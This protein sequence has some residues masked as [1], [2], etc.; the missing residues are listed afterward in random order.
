[1]VSQD[2][3]S[4]RREPRSPGLLI[5]RNWLHQSAQDTPGVSAKRGGL[6]LPGLR[7]GVPAKN[8]DRRSRSSSRGS[9]MSKAVNI[10]IIGSGL[11]GSAFI[12]SLQTLRSPSIQ[13]NV[14]VIARSSRAL[15]S[16]N[17][18]PLPLANWASDLASTTSSALNPG[19]LAAYLEKSPLPVILVDNTSSETLA[20]I[21]PLFL[22][23]GISIATPNKKGFSDE[24]GLWRAIFSAAANHGTDKAAPGGLVYHEATVGAGLPIISTLKDLIATGDSIQKIEGIV[25]GTL[26]YIFNTYSAADGAKFSDIVSEAKE[27]GYTE[28]DPRED[29]N[30][31]DVARKL[32]ILARLSGLDVKSATSFPVESLIPKPLEEVESV[33]EFMEK[34]PQYDHQSEKLK[35]EAAAEGKVLRYVGKVDLTGESAQKVSVGIQKYDSAHP[36]A[37]L[38]G[39]DNVIAFYTKRY[40]KNPVIVQGA[41][42]GA[43]VT[44]MGVLGDVIKIAERIAK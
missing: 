12:N 25:S 17:Y 26:S 2:S 19:D 35:G 4:A 38:K 8:F 23:Q 42:A 20:R 24:L 13:Y 41:G 32:T 30:G 5:D 3:P 7:T 31:L 15:V 1:M 11:V 44:A 6:L 39:S 14:I 18:T 40:G 22:S 43:E 34:L 16:K 10:A 9:N 36:F 29:L 28:P 33:A 37:S 21:Y 27:L